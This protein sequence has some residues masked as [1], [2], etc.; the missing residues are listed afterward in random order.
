MSPILIG[1]LGLLCLLG[2]ILL[3]VPI[4]AA[5]ALVGV[6]GTLVLDPLAS[7]FS[8]FGTSTVQ[9]LSSQ[10][11]IVIPLFILMGGFAI[12]SGL[13]T[14]I[15]RLA[16]AWGGHLRGGLAITTVGTS[17]IFG[18]ICGS[19]VATTATMVQVALPEMRRRGY[20][21]AL[22]AGSIAG[23]GTLGSLIPPSVIMVVYAILT[24]QSV[25]DLFRAAVIP[26]LV[27]IALYFLA[28]RLFLMRHPGDGQPAPRANWGE[29][30]RATTQARLTLLV[31]GVM[32]GGIYSGIFTV[33]EGAAIGVLLVLAASLLR[34]KLTRENFA[35]T[36][37]RAASNIGMIYL[38]LIG[39]EIYKS[40]LTLSGLPAA[41]VAWVGGLDLP[42]MVIISVVILLYLAL[43]CVF[44][45]M[46]AMILTMPFVFPLVVS[47]LGFDPVWWGIMNVMIIE[48]GMITPPV[49]IN[50]FVLNG[51]RPDLAIKD[52]YRGITPFVAVDLIRIL[53]FLLFP[54]LMLVLV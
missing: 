35:A 12:V 28:I 17:A 51:M 42:P 22:I 40:F 50:I 8:L 6:I 37:I 9:A 21:D 1:G 16:H 13:S 54:G 49:G 46:A 23:G 3:N 31:A 11:L 14:E 39:A 7:V 47:Q 48:I 34:K 29:R 36:L 27:A 38:I 2:V 45:A 32:L 53:I 41:T 20:S 4:A 25:L 5:M 26:G 18:A 10:D 43:G 15:Y 52:I 24:Q 44:D 19:S 33:T 30:V